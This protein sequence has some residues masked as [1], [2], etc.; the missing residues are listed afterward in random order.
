PRA[1]LA[2][3]RGPAP[4]AVVCDTKRVTIGPNNNQFGGVIL[5]E[6]ITESQFYGPNLG[7]VLE[8]YERYIEDPGSVDE[9]A[10]SFFEN[11]SPPEPGANGNTTATASADS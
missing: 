3:S 10:R 6:N 2:S 4:T 1:I 11:W 5:L 9:R 8:L 7:Y